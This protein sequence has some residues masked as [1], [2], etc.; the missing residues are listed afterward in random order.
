MRR[1]KAYPLKGYFKIYCYTIVSLFPE[2]YFEWHLRMVSLSQR[3]ESKL[4]GVL[5]EINK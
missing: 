3:L 4:R 5:S 1:I 2:E